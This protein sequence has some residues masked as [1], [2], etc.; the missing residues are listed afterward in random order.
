MTRTLAFLC[1]IAV[2]G[3]LS[4]LARPEADL[5][6]TKVRAGSTLSPALRTAGARVGDT[7]HTTVDLV[8][9]SRNCPVCYA[10]IHQLASVHATPPDTRRVV[11]ITDLAWPELSGLAG[12]RVKVVSGDTILP[13]GIGLRA[14]PTLVAYE[15]RSGHVRLVAVGRPAVDTRFVLPSSVHF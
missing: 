4:R 12:P 15:N 13:R 3:L 10:W 7:T 6:P 9:I 5:S 8:F 11:F 14:T 2:F 1:V